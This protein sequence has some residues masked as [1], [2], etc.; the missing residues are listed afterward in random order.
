MASSG[1]FPPQR[2]YWKLGRIAR[3]LDRELDMVS[4]CSALASLHPEAVSHAGK[5]SLD[6]R[7]TNR[8]VRSKAAR[9]QREQ[10]MNLKPAGHW[11]L[12][13]ERA[14]EAAMIPDPRTR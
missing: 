10:G 3:S 9:N 11:D 14:G 4:H 12:H 7:T 6:P 5:G 13:L 2:T 8:N 1:D